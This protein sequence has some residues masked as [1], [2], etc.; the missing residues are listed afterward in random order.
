MEQCK[1]RRHAEKRRRERGD[2]KRM[3]LENNG[4]KEDTQRREGVNGTM[5]EEDM[6]SQ[7]REEIPRSPLQLTPCCLS[8]TRT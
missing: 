1:K 7:S 2:E 4:R 5:E 3:K 6:Q 8:P